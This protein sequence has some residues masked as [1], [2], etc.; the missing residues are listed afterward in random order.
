[1]NIFSLPFRPLP[2]SSVP[3]VKP[4][5]KEREAS[6]SRTFSL[7]Q[8]RGGSDDVITAAGGFPKKSRTCEHVP[9]CLTSVA[10]RQFGGVGADICEADYS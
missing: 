2:L 3:V 1:M 9:K 10:V 7:I 4:C 6:F 5:L 8:K